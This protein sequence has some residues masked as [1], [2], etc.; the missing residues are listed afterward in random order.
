V[1]NCLCLVTRLASCRLG[2]V[3]VLR[4]MSGKWARVEKLLLVL[5]VGL[6]SA[7]GWARLQ[8][9]VESRL[10]LRRFHQPTVLPGPKQSALDPFIDRPVD[11]GLWSEKR[12]REYPESLISKQGRPV[13]VLRVPSLQIEVPVFDGTD[14]LTLNRDVGRIIGTARV[15]PPGNKAL[16]GHRDGFFRPLKDISVGAHLEPVTPD[17]TIHYTVEKTG[18]VSPDDVSVLVDQGSPA[19]TLVNCFPFYFVGDAPQRFI[20]QAKAADFYGPAT[21][22]SALRSQIKP[23]VVSQQ[24]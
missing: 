13:G 4:V 24:C 9:E 21:E 20:V 3:R 22:R 10:A 8:N 2:G 16:A 7:Y 6:L 17:S 19:L 5:G 1:I 14:D 18:I 23:E 15:G 11:F 12:I